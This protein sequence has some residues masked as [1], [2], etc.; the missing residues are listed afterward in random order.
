MGTTQEYYAKKNL[1][2]T[3]DKTR[4][5]RPL[6]SHLKKSSKKHEQDMLGTD[7]EAWMNS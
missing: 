2:A 7:G 3:P 1:D 6:T 4:A 5:V